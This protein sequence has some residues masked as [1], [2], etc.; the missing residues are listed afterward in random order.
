MEELNIRHFKLYN[1]DEILALVQN[2]NEFNYMIETPVAI[3]FNMMGGFQFTPW[4]PFSDQKVFRLGK[5]TIITSG[6]VLQEIKEQY[7][8]FALKKREVAIA[9]SNEELLTRLREYS[10][11]VLDEDEEWDYAD[12]DDKVVH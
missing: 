8:Q 11:S 9:Q 5:E 3:N 4:F 6:G 10:G 1:G 7:L 12:M 2:S